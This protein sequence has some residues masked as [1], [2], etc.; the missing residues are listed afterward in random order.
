MPKFQRAS[1]FLTKE[2]FRALNNY[3]IILSC[4]PKLVLVFLRDG[5]LATRKGKNNFH[6]IFC[7]DDDDDVE[8]HTD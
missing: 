3:C 4:L 7:D 1:R 5:N 8:V 6:K 2:G